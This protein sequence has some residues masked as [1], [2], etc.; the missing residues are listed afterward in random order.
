MNRKSFNPKDIYPD[1]NAVTKEN[2]VG[3][4]A[5]ISLNSDTAP[6]KSSNH[7]LIFGL[8]GGLLGLLIVVGI[9][10]WMSKEEL[11]IYTISGGVKN[12]AE[13][14]RIQNDLFQIKTEIQI[15]F[16][17]K[18]TYLGYK[19]NE[20]L[21]KD[22][23]NIGSELKIA[24]LSDKTFVIYTTLS[25]SDFYCMDNDGFTGKVAAEPTGLACQ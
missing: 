22:L 4:P 15:Y 12:Q 21:K 14:V 25:T 5:C 19:P 7:S 23:A 8:G 3:A 10:M 1:P 11:Q 18:Q 6:K 20:T 17:E 16:Q 2:S 13:D 24:V 9:I